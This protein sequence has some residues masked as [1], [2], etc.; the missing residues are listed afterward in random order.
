MSASYAA[1]VE[2]QMPPLWDSSEGAKYTLVGSPGEADEAATRTFYR[3]SARE[4]LPNPRLFTP[5]MLEL[6]SLYHPPLYEKLSH[7][8]FRALSTRAVSAL[9]TAEALPSTRAWMRSMLFLAGVTLS[10]AIIQNRWSVG[11][12]KSKLMRL[13]Q[14]GSLVSRAQVIDELKPLDLRKRVV[15]LALSPEPDAGKLLL[16]KKLYARAL[17][18]LVEPLAH[19][20]RTLQAIDASHPLV[21]RFGFVPGLVS[22]LGRNL[23]AVIAYGSSVT[24]SNYADFDLIL[25]V[26]DADA[27]LALLAGKSPAWE[28]CELNMSVHSED[29]FRTYQLASGDNLIDYGLCLYGETI[30]PHKPVNDLLHRNFSFGY[31]RMRQIMGMAA[32]AQEEI[33]VDPA[34]DKANLY[35]YFLK[36]PANVY[37]G[38]HGVIAQAMSKDRV[39]AL[40]RKRF[41]FDLVQLGREPH[42]GDALASAAWC[43]KELLF[44]LNRTFS[45]YR[46][47]EEAALA[48]SALR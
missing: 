16:L 17:A 15:E 34:D 38:T 5:G 7:S 14:A 13:W 8:V 30:V 20:T 11:T 32:A 48:G 31:V 36:I 43:T 18:P 24:S 12:I 2:I 44:E 41:G 33:P 28:G 47:E 22:A 25:V 39:A 3:E 42:L 4:G 29:D 46:R 10:A 26:R 23:R 40:L 45:V 1:K 35:G 27:A 37:K 6:V 21:R 9:P 19:T